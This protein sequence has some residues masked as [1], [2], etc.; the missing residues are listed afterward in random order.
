MCR[1]EVCSCILCAP[2]KQEKGAMD[3]MVVDL[4]GSV[5]VTVLLVA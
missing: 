1:A 5:F 3:V 2:N 4:E